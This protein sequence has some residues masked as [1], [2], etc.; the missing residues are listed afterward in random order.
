[1]ANFGPPINI[2]EA[3]AGDLAKIGIKLTV[4]SE[5]LSVWEANE[6]GPATKRWSGMWV[7]GPSESRRKWVRLVSRPSQYVIGTAQYSGLRSAECGQA[8]Q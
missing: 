4:E 8:A 7:G 1:M 5:A 3:I 6:T 2:N